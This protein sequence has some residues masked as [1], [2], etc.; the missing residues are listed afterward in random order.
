MDADM[1]ENVLGRIPPHGCC[2]GYDSRIEA[3]DASIAYRGTSPEYDPHDGRW[4]TWPGA[5]CDEPGDARFWS[6]LAVLL[7]T[8]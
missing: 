7:T 1:D 5:R 3:L 8:G 2:V 4:Y 6:Q